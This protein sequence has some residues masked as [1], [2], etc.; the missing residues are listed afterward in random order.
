[1]DRSR[2]ERFDG[3]GSGLCVFGDEPIGRRPPATTQPVPR[4]DS[5]RRRLFSHASSSP[6]SMPAPRVSFNWTTRCSEYHFAQCEL[7]PPVAA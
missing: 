1:M 4:S 7:S 6:T 5:E 3:C 2:D